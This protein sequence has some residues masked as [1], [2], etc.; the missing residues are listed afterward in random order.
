M[1]R[2]TVLLDTNAYTFL[3][4]GDRHVRRYIEKAAIVYISVITIGELLVG[5]K[6]GKKERENKELLEEFLL[7]STVKTFQVTPVTA[8]IYATI[9]HALQKAGAPIPINDVWI[10]AQAQ[11]TGS[12]LIT[13]DPHFLRIPGLRLWD[14][15]LKKN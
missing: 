9:K 15:L 14:R 10:A 1:V 12:L 13:Y 5:F 2:H 3:R 4:K 6:N 11:E 8:E 7:E